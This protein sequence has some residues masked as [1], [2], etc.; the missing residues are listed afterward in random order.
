[1][2]NVM[3]ARFN[4]LNSLNSEPHCTHFTVVCAEHCG[5]TTPQPRTR[6]L[7]F[8]SNMHFT[9]RDLITVVWVGLGFFWLTLDCIYWKTVFQSGALSRFVVQ[10]RR[11]LEANPLIFLANRFRELSGTQELD[12]RWR[13]DLGAHIAHFRG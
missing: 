2:H 11:I 5:A 1:M 7:K 9:L 6:E 4:H 10:S 13:C 8:C 12:C 3:P